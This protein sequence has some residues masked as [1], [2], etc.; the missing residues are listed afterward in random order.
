MSR[1]SPGSVALRFF[2]QMRCWLALASDMASDLFSRA[3]LFPS[4]DSLWK[5]CE[6]SSC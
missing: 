4:R 5:F 6:R 3:L 2:R 1:I